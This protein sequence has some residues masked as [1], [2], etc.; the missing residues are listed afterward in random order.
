MLKIIDNLEK[1]FDHFFSILADDSPA[2]TKQFLDAFKLAQEQYKG[3]INNWSMGWIYM[4]TRTRGKSIEQ[5]HKV[6]ETYPDLIIRLQELQQILPKTEID[7][8]K[9]QSMTLHAFDSILL[10]HFVNLVPG[11]L[12]LKEKEK[13]V[14]FPRIMEML[15]SKIKSF[16]AD[17]KFIER[18][19]IERQKECQKIPQKNNVALTK[20]I[21]I[22][23]LVNPMNPDINTSLS[24]EDLIKQGHFNTF[25][26]RGM[27][28]KYSLN[29]LNSIEKSVE[30]PLKRYPLLDKWLVTLE[31]IQDDDLVKLK[32]A[33]TQVTTCVK[34]VPLLINPDSPA[35]KLSNEDLIKKGVNSTFI[36]RTHDEKYNLYW[37]NSLNTPVEINL[38]DYPAFNKWLNNNSLDECNHSCLNEYLCDINTGKPVGRDD[39]KQELN[40]FFAR[41]QNLV[42]VRENTSKPLD[43]ERYQMVAALFAKKYGTQLTPAKLNLDNYAA[44]TSLFGH[45]T[46]IQSDIK[47]KVQEDNLPNKFSSF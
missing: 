40:H 31:S 5:T 43:L 42:P 24:N 39:L 9:D 27:K 3:T 20:F 32:E 35:G 10:E 33:L 28:G 44:V 37:I 34:K 16:Q 23:L 13:P 26:L 45:K 14:V 38:A 25:I 21:E 41:G 15:L 18:T 29:W 7:A 2:G 6:I 11:Y 30:I 47:N 12:P 19:K 17:N 22:K 1:F 8:T 46:D 36:L 4:F